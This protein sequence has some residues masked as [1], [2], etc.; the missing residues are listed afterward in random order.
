MKYIALL[1]I[2]LTPFFSTNAQVID[3]LIDVGNHRLHFKIMKGKGIPILFEAG[4]GDDGSAWEKLLQPLHD[5]TGAT[6]ISYDRA[7]LGKSEIDTLRIG[8]KKEVKNLEYALKQLGYSGEKFLVS[9]SFG[10]FYS[11][12]YARRNKKKIKGAV[13]IEVALPCFFTPQWSH[14]FVE[15]IKERDLKFIKQHKVGLYYVLANMENI[16][17]YMSNKLLPRKIPATV[18]GAETAPSMLQQKQDEMEKWKKCLQSYGTMPNH[19][20]VLAEGCG[21]KVWKDN[22]ELVINEIVKLYKK[23]DVEKNDK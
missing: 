22:P 5:S 13:F 6:L 15:N 16:S 4:N 18:I 14:D 23:V 20:Y 21:H 7:G 2:Y 11:T 12:L 10:G 9:H 19:T 17:K 3:T 8:F 1:L